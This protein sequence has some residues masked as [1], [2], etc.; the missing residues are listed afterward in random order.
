MAGILLSH[1][2]FERITAAVTTRNVMSE[3]RIGT[4]VRRLGLAVQPLPQRL[5][6]TIHYEP[7]PI[8]TRAPGIYHPVKQ[9]PGEAAG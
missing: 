2:A 4:T 6:R 3:L 8:G 7:A 1:H 9:L 5:R